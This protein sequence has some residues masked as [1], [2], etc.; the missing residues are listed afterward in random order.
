MKLLKTLPTRSEWIS[1]LKYFDLNQDE[2]LQGYKDIC[3][4][5]LDSY[6][7]V[8]DTITMS[9]SILCGGIRVYRQRLEF[10]SYANALAFELSLSIFITFILKIDFDF[11]TITK[12]ELDNKYILILCLKTTRSTSIFVDI[13]HL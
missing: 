6:H 11:Y 9:V 10:E 12:L 13:T 4:E 8:F 3:L 2:C 7:I 5:L 1:R